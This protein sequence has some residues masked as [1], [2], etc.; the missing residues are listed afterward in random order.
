MDISDHVG[1]LNCSWSFLEQNVLSEDYFTEN[2]S[3]YGNETIN[4]SD[5][6][7]HEFSNCSST[8]YVC[9]CVQQVYLRF[10]L[11]LTPEYFSYIYRIIGTIFQGAFSQSM[12]IECRIES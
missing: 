9:L 1:D 2:D 10:C 11:L 5:P 8:D 7:F 12:N 3:F 4:C 6:R